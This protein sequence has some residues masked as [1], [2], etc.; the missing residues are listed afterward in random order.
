MVRVTNRVCVGVIDY[1]KCKDKRS[2]FKQGYSLY[3]ENI[4]QN[5]TGYLHN[6][7]IS[8][9]TLSIKK[10]KTKQSIGEGKTMEIKIKDNKIFWNILNSSTKLWSLSLDVFEY[11]NCMLVPAVEIYDQNDIMEVWF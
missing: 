10:Y 11:Q 8:S 7:T 4:I 6:F 9:N 1:N 2:S 3:Y 5:N